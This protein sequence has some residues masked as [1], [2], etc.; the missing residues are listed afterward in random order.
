MLNSWLRIIFCRRLRDGNPCLKDQLEELKHFGKMACINFFFI[1]QQSGY[2]I[3]ILRGNGMVL[4]ELGSPLCGG[5]R[6]C[7][8]ARPRSSTVDQMVLS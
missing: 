3:F 6:S 8:V 4:G 5:E 1:N 7:P 2:I